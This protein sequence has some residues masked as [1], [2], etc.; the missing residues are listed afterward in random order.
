MHVRHHYPVVSRGES[1]REASRC[2]KKAVVR[3]LLAEDV[4]HLDSIGQIGSDAAVI[5]CRE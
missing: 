3:L 1:V 5:G 2:R 4:V